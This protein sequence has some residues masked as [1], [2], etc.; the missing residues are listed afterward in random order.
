MLFQQTTEAAQ[1]VFCAMWW[2]DMKVPSEDGQPPIPCLPYAPC[3]ASSQTEMLW[4]ARCTCGALHSGCLPLLPAYGITSES[5]AVGVSMGEV[6]GCGIYPVGCPY[7]TDLS[8][9]PPTWRELSPSANMLVT[10]MQA[11]TSDCDL[12]QVQHREQRAEG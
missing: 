12:S 2:L 6:K 1:H 11:E 4:S 3:P 5:Q 7:K 10:C 9:V 8:F